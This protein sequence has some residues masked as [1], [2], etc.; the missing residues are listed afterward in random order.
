MV[1][2]TSTTTT[3]ITTTVPAI[4]A[5]FPARLGASAGGLGASAVV[6]DVGN[7]RVGDMEESVM[8]VVVGITVAIVEL[9]LTVTVV[10]GETIVCVWIVEVNGVCM[11]VV[12]GKINELVDDS[13]WIVVVSI[14]GVVVGTLVVIGGLTKG[15][16]VI[17]EL[18]EGMTL[19]E[20]DKGTLDG[21]M[22]DIA[23]LG[24]TIDDRSEVESLG[25]VSGV[26]VVRGGPCVD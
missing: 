22:L 6:L 9:V 2:N 11:M 13:C 7:G 10:I 12:V 8:M 24:S 25:V 21:G 1:T 17:G 14:P 26:M 3:T 16:L 19:V 23:E 5:S 18:R 20:G 4:T 15:E